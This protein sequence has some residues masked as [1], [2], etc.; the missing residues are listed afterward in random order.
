MKRRFRPIG[1]RAECVKAENGNFRERT[2]AL[3]VLFVRSQCTA[4]KRI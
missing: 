1:R 2:K 4:E 3:L